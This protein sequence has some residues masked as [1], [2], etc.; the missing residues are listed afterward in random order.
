MTIKIG[1]NGFGRI[2]RQ[3]FRIISQSEGIEVFVINALTDASTLAH[4]L[5]YDSVHGKF[6]GTI[7]V[8]ED[9]LIVNGK[10]TKVCSIKDPAVLPWKES[11][12]DTGA[13][14]RGVDILGFPARLGGSEW[15]LADFNLRGLARIK[16]KTALKGTGSHPKC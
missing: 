7:E 2:G 6:S 11:G 15:L 13:E 3:I 9:S 12:V 16:L 8:R 4:L 14:I 1:I 5:K 10:E